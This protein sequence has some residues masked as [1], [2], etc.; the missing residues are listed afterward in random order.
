M[1]FGSL[2]AAS[3]AAGDLRL[4]VDCTLG[5][6]C[7]IQQHVDRDPGPGAVDFTCGT[8]T[9]DGHDGTDFRLVDD[10][11]MA[12][13]VNVLAAAPGVVQ[14][15]RDDVPD[16]ASGDAEAPDVN[17][18]ECGNGVL[19]ERNDQWR[20]QYCHLRKGS[21]RV[22]WGQT[23]E[24]GQVLGQIGLSGQ[25]QFPHLH[26]TVRDP[27]GRVIDPFDARPQDADCA[28]ADTDTLWAHPIAYAP[29]GV[30]GA[31][32]LDRL[33]DYAEVRAGTAAAPGLGTDA[34]AL[35]FWAHFYGLRQGDR[36]EL[37]LTAPDGSVLA[38]MAHVMDRTRAAEFR[39]VGRKAQGAW[40]AGD[41]RGTAIL[42]RNG[43][44]IGRVERMLTV[45]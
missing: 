1:L 18:R 17:G 24:A 39:A 33:P 43:A 29:S 28:L 10:A 27:Q 8:L 21:I 5:Q 36:L 22:T 12:A 11:A 6:D 31:G 23:V 4:P 25:T 20:L 14:A 2:L 37:G 45:D 40:P 7:F 19:V 9:Y 3:A 38:E 44:A 16:V 15:I 13:G 35:V 42:S 32:F 41:Y 34:P 26:L 30:L